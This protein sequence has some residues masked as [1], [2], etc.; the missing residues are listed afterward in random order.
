MERIAI[1]GAAGLIGRLLSADLSTDHQVTSL[2]RAW[3]S[4]ALRLRQ[5]TRRISFAQ[6]AF[7]GASAVIDLA[8]NPQAGV[9]WRVATRNNIPA[10][11]GCFEAARRAGVKRV[12]YASSNHVTGLYER[13][14]PY[15]SICAGDLDELEPMSIPR[16][17]SSWP[18]RPDGPYAVGKVLGEASARYYAEEYG[19]SIICIRIGTV[20]ADDRPKSPRGFAT[21][22]THADMTRLV[23][24]CLSAR[25]EVSFGVVY[26]VSA[27]TWRFWDTDEAKQL[28]GWEPLDDAERW[29]SS[30]AD[31]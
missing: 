5:N 13:D 10:T 1:T 21:I 24:A 22:L 2:D 30:G 20:Y 9:G 4:G 3:R 31:S 11:L 26:G 18:I 8:A 23:R 6:Q 17:T 15:R 25:P 7:T 29:R 27:N 14:E 28:V 19:M 16:I 12:I